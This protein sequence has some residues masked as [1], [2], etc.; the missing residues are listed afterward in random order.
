MKNTLL[1]TSF[2]LFLTSCSSGPL[3]DC[4]GTPLNLKPGQ[5]I[6]E[7]SSLSWNECKAKMTNSKGDIYTTKFKNGLPY[8]GLWEYKSE[9]SF[10][11]GQ[12]ALY[13]KGNEI[14]G[15]VWHGQGTLTSPEGGKWIGQFKYHQLVK[16][17][18]ISNDGNQYVGEWKDNKFHGQGTYT[19]ADG[20]K[21]VG[22]F[23]DD[24]KNGQ[25]TE[26]FLNGDSYVGEYKDDEK[27]GQGTYTWADGSKYVGVYKDGLKNGQGTETL[28]DGTKLIG[29]FKNDKIRQGVMANP[30][31]SKYVGEFDKNGLIHGM[32]TYTWADGT[33]KKGIW[34]SDQITKQS[35]LVTEIPDDLMLSCKYSRSNGR[36]S[37]KYNSQ[38]RFLRIHDYKKNKNSGNG[39]ITFYQ[40][41]RYNN[42]RGYNNSRI[43]FQTEQEV[44]FFDDIISFQISMLI[45]NTTYTLNRSTLNL[46]EKFSG[47]FDGYNDVASEHYYNCRVFTDSEFVE[48]IKKIYSDKLQEKQ[49]REDLIKRNKI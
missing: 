4:E 30:D 16:G 35:T 2:I 44:T 1:P 39:R 11:E 43:D 12:L 48:F 24:K 8:E 21:Y 36:V 28:P 31:G 23:R 17:T 13:I 41:S 45:A 25:G 49:Q 32:G 5:K 19:W 37:D 33:F 47:M 10:Y 29:D 7:V 20:T 38:D 26:N 46:V 40:V 27:N 42:S 9:G 18:Y 15:T 22:E 3:P 14:L 34:A 6:H